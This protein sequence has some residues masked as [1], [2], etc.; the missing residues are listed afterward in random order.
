MKLQQKKNIFPYE[1]YNA[2]FYIEKICGSWYLRKNLNTRGR[3]RG[4]SLEPRLF[5]CHF[6]EID[7]VFFYLNLKIIYCRWTLTTGYAPNKK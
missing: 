3:N 1:V 2:T 4:R 6:I 7:H 5:L